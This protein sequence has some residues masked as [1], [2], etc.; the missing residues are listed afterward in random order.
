[1][2]FHFFTIAI[3]TYNRDAVLPYSL[4]AALGQNFDRKKFEILVVTNNCTDKTQIL[5]DDYMSRQSNVRCV[6]ETRQG[7]S[8]ARNKAIDQAKGDMI[9]Y[10]DDDAEMSPHY[11]SHLEKIIAEE[12]KI[13]A[14]GGPV[15]VGWLGPVPAWYETGL[16]R[17]FNYLYYGSYRMKLRYP[18][19]VYG[20]NMAF[21]VSLLKKI[22]GFRTDL[23]RIG[24]SLLSG[25]DV[26]I[27]LRIQEKEHLPI[28]Y[29]PDLRVKHLISPE[30]LSPGYIMEK[31]IWQGRS[32]YRLERLFHHKRGVRNALWCLFESYARMALGKGGGR[33]TERFQ[34]SLAKGIV[35]EWA[36]GGK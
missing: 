7:L 29:D 9:V 25:E 21:P 34:R 36:H 17:A 26:E 6:N 4:N 27:M 13:G 30:R 28:L 35:L 33:L 2:T 10:V 24:A 12:E 1:L 19:V 11:L 32:Q 22:G 8:F 14:L 18:R 15:E 23:G 20:T 31:A 16:D 5:I 3:C